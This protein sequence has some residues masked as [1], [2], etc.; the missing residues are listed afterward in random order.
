[1]AAKTEQ[2]QLAVREKTIDNTC[3]SVEVAR[4]H[5]GMK[6]GRKQAH[7]AHDHAE[8][9]VESVPAMCRKHFEHD[10]VEQTAVDRTR[11]SQAPWDGHEACQWFILFERT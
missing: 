2:P 10:G 4:N 5:V 3:Y 7:T 9:T 11:L 1:M 8:Q 6:N